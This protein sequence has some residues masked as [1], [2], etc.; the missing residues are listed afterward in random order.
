[1]VRIGVAQERGVRV[2]VDVREAQGV[3]VAAYP[4]LRQGPVRWQIE[5]T[6]AGVVLTA[7][8]ATTP[9]ESVA[10]DAPALVAATATVDSEG[11]VQALEARGTL[12]E[13]ARQ[14]AAAVAGA[15]DVAEALTAVGA[16]YAPGDARVATLLPVGL[17]QRL[18]AGVVRETTFRAESEVLA[19]AL[20]WRVEL[21][22]TGAVPQRYTLVF[23]PIDGRLM[24]LVRR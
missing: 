16:K 15:G 19:E 2:P 13:A 1:V 3:L 6:D 24:S 17:Q 23:E 11:R 14:R 10:R 22:T 20:T 5:A 9:F 7:R 4:E 8:P 21:D 12:L 18:G